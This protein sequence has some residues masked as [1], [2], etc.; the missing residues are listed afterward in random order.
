MIRPSLRSIAT[1]A[2]PDAIAFAKKIRNRSSRQR[3]GSG[4]CS[5]ISGSDATAKSAS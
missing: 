5:Q 2:P 4:C 3:S 1:S